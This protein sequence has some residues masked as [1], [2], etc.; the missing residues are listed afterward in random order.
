M[1]L[2]YVIYFKSSQVIV[3]K[4]RHGSLSVYPVTFPLSSACW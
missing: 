4:I 3:V 2:D 1:H